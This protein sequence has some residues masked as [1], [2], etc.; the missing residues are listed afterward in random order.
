MF[1]GIVSREKGTPWPDTGM[2]SQKWLS[3]PVRA[4]QARTLIATQ[5]GVYLKPLLEPETP[6]GGDEYPHVIVYKQKYYLEDGHHRVIKAMIE[7]RPLIFARVLH[8]D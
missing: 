2:T 5:D 8:V 4:V 6:V 3:I 1:A 7:G